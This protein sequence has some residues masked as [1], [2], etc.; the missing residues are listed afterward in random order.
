MTKNKEFTYNKKTSFI[1]IS[2]ERIYFIFFIFFLISLIFSFKVISLGFKYLPEEKLISKKENFRASIKDRNG[3]LLAKSVQ[4]TNVGINPNLVIDK[5]KLLLS[6]KIIFPE[7]NFKKKLYGKKFF[8]L[9]KKISPKKLQ[10]VRLLGDKSIIEEDSITRV[11]PNGRLFSHVLGQINTENEGISGLEKSYDYEL[12]TSKK[13]LELTL[14]TEI[15]Y[16]MREELNKFQSVFKSYGSA[17]ILMDI[18]S[19]E[20]LSMV[21]LPDFNLNLRKNINDPKYINRITKGVYEFG[22][23]FKTLTVA[24]GLKY[25]VVNLNT[26]FV[27]LPKKIQCSGSSI[28][29]YDKDIP[30]DLTVEDILIRSGNIGSVRIA[31]KVG[32]DNFKSFLE[33]L[34]LLKKINFD[35]DEVGSPIPFNW[36]KC[37]LA[38]ASFGHGITTTPIQL[39]KAY[40]IIA[41]GGFDINPHLVKKQSIKTKREVINKEISKKIVRTLRK[42]VTTENGTANLANIKGY[43]IGGKTGTAQK[44][45][46]GK[47]SNKKKINTFASIFPS[48]NPKFALIVLL[49]E[50]QLSKDYVYTYND[51]EE[52]KIIGTPFNTAGWTSV[53]VAARII[54]KIGPILA[55]KY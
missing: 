34:D 45:I 29:E 32:I 41:N 24:A 38:T 8:Y 30:K 15:Q 9:E 12:T 4:I 40:S 28:S 42:I 47:Y 49:D 48:S 1:T 21:S 31:Q 3:N 17:S 35:L 37:K 14:D 46:G 13:P 5:Q 53:E 10:Q 54:E 25:N 20:I 44:T 7:K 27:D 19:G 2:Q 16:L 23:V 52:K 50:P 55:I 26:K 36:G 43:E 6:L 33:D 22:S 11:Y 39:A 51:S 18:N